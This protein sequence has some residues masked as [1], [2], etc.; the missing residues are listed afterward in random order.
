MI[1]NTKDKLSLYI[2]GKSL[3][4]N[5]QP[6][7]PFYG[8]HAL[9][10]TSDS[11]DRFMRYLQKEGLRTDTLQY[12]ENS[13]LHLYYTLPENKTLDKA[14]LDR[15]RMQL[16]A[17]DMSWRPVNF[18][19]SAANGYLSWMNR[20][21]LHL[22]LLLHPKTKMCLELTPEEY[23]Q[24]LHA[25]V[26]HVNERLYL[27]I[28]VLGCSG[29]SVEDL[30]EL[31]VERLKQD[32]Q[33]PFRNENEYFLRVPEVLKKDLLDYAGRKGIHSGPVFITKKGTLMDTSNI[34]KSIRRICQDSGIDKSKT[35]FSSLNLMYYK[36]I[37]ELQSKAGPLA[38]RDYEILLEQEELLI[39]W[40]RRKNS[41][42]HGCMDRK[43]GVGTG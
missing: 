38:E 13:L 43:A 16:I 18:K 28:K 2:E 10:M 34:R 4:G 22:K 42:Y 9:H 36:R 3:I 31:T 40:S 30:P 1:Q 17:E 35:K 8:E 12:C 19:L 15:W 29:I 6:E 25:S 14:A 7:I 26:M 27:L 21:D 39:G 23:Q 41:L 11:I 33:T 5:L 32:K 20:Q 24:I 37:T